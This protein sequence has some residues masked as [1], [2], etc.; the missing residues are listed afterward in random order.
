MYVLPVG[1]GEAEKITDVKSGVGNYDWS[2]DGKMI[3]FVM[4]DVAS[5]KEEKD[6][7]SKNDWYFVDEVVK[8]NKL[9]VL[10]LNEKDT[11]GKKKQKQVVKEN[12]NI[13][14]FD[15]SA[16][17]KNIA[18][19]HGKSPEVND[20]VYSDISL[21]ELETG[22]TRSIASTGAGESNPSLAPMEN[23]SSITAPMILWIGPAPATQKF[24]LWLMENHGA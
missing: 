1:G 17:G 15:W 9:Y 20:N 19:S 13:N 23:S 7:K 21:V 4:A 5:D 16:D 24:I 18:Y 11:S 6:K 3:A 14:A 8:Q 2:H 12:Y 10:W 22:K